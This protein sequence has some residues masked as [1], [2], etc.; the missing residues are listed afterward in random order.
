[1]PSTY[2]TNLG[3][4]KIA[5][6]E[7]SG[8]WG[9]T[10]NTNL[11]LIDEAVNGVEQVTLSVA[12]S[13]G[14]P[15]DLPITNGTSSDGRNKFIEFID[16]GDL[17]G[18]AF[19]QL[20]PNDAEKVVHIRNSL[21]AARSIIIFQ[22]TYNASNDFEIPNGA[23]VVLK[24][25]GAG[26]GAVVSDV[27]VNLTPTKLTTPDLVATTA[28]INGG[29]IDG[30]TIATSDITVGSGKTLDVSAGTLTLANDQISGDKIEG[31]TIGSVTI[32]SLTATS[33]DI[34]GGTI[35]GATVD[36]RDISA[37]GSKLDGIESGADVTDTAN[38]TAAGALMDSELTSEASVKALDQGVATTDSPSFA[39]LT[40]TTADINGGTIDNT[41]IGGSTP[42]AGSF[43]D[44]TA[45]EIT[46]S[47][48]NVGA[49]LAWNSST[50][51]YTANTTPS[52]VTKIHEG[53]K[54]CILKADG[55][56]NYYLNPSD[57]TE[58]IDGTS[59][60]LD[61]TDGYVMVEIPKFYFRYVLNGSTHNW[62][63]S[64][65]P[66]AGFQLHP[67]FYKDEKIVDYR[68]IGAYD[69]C[70]LDDTD[71][72]YK[73]G[74]NL[75]DM[76]SNI[77]PNA[78]KLASVSGIYPLV[79]VTR[80]ECRSLAENN[81]AGWRVADFWLTSAIQMLY[82]VE[83]GSFYSQNIT[84][85]GNTGASYVSSS[86]SQTDSPHSIA[87]KSNS[88]GNASTNTTT[89]ASSASRDTAFMSYRGIENFYGNCWNWVD[90]VNIGVGANYNVHVSNVTTDFKD[91]DSAD[92]DLIGQCATANG[93]VQNI[94]AG[95]VPGAF[96]PID[97][98][99]ASSSTYLTDQFFINTG[100]RV[101]LFGGGA[102][103]GAS[104][105]AFFW[106]W[107]NDSLTAGRSIG[108]RVAY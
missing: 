99:G 51:A 39:G 55:S 79:G 16:G 35:D 10:T 86:S 19:V 98:T 63:I 92:Y 40:A 27:Y 95:D 45:E 14:S 32:S 101:A 75:D 8:T 107:F 90:G 5:T 84:G 31:G 28:D 12:G 68:Y 104:A 93:Y 64:D 82:V 94:Y 2:T 105:G 61:G 7:Q 57:S 71:S 37:D 85:A 89:G 65:V 3:I 50:D 80:D 42:A 56:V 60:T 87:G 77:D 106:S 17:G 66:Q 9:T 43:T 36:G 20:T 24:F 58:K 100:N 102:S 47:R 29:T 44:V 62:E 67:A 76:T 21:S 46:A 41:T 72:T 54:R 81:G 52:K 11:D 88:L 33:A 97:T 78:D 30:A 74:L 83:F 91:D 73:S 1:M 18:T 26:A 103:S 53:M 70:Y 22:G 108:A 34:N 49:N 59:A 6:G 69:A 38:V 15:N 48:L 4:E 96:I 13:S 23:D 25:D